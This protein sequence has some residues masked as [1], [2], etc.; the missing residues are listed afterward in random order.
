M[1][2]KTIEQAD[3]LRRLWSSFW[4]AR[5]LLTA[6][7]FDLFEHTKTEAT[8]R[9]VAARIKADLRATEILMDALAALGL[10]KKTRLSRGSEKE[11]GK[12]SVYRNSR[13][14]ALFLVKESPYYQG[15]IVR[16][17]DDT[18]KSWSR[19]EEAMRTGKPVPRKGG[20][21]SLDAF[22]MGMH[23]LA[24]LRAGDIIKAIGMKGVESAL[25][26]GGGPGT[27]SMEMAKAG[28][29][30]VTLFDRSDVVKIAAKNI[31]KHGAAKRNN[32]GFMRG[33]F[34]SDDFGSGYDLIFMSN[35]LHSN[36]FAE[37]EELLV[38]A[39][40]ALNP[41]G[42]AA[43]NEF[44]LEDNR[45]APLYGALFSV[46]MLVNTPE[47]RTYTGSE[48]KGFLKKAGFRDIRGRVLF[49]D[50]VIVTGRA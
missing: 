20:E 4:Q 15:A 19:L 9:K 14:A 7:N 1:D 50:T 45:T 2:K 24:V 12:E 38:R 41:A 6:V 29:R 33:D 36:S 48:L 25:D 26:L 21:F 40:A 34:N 8:A 31:K 18:W 39:R 17:A 28:V 32:I 23:N 16:H 30:K 22:I 35:I 43:I 13:E 11:K 5:P 3:G 37:C 46:N 42:R 49:G 27:Y 44:Y 47:G 10:L